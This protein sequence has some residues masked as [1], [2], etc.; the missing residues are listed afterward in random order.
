MRFM[1]QR[2]AGVAVPEQLGYAVVTRVICHEMRTRP[3]TR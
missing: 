3:S 2:R 1:E